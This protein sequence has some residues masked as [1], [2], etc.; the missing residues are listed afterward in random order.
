MMEPTCHTPIH[1]GPRHGDDMGIADPLFDDAAARPDG[2]H[3]SEKIAGP[4][5]AIT[6]NHAGTENEDHLPAGDGQESQ[7][8]EHHQQEPMLDMGCFQPS[9]VK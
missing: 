4:G 2:Q 6:G 1:G 8:V 5:G 3:P 7:G 9:T